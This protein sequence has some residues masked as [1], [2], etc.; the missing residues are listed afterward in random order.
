MSVA[1][2]TCDSSCHCRWQSCHRHNRLLQ[3]RAS[4][5]AIFAASSKGCASGDERMTCSAVDL[6]SSS[7][8][9]LAT[10]DKMRMDFPSRVCWE[11]VNQQGW[12]W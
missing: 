4:R 11:G 6:S 1:E 10:R 7:A 5:T 12:P 9:V 3:S 2:N 8:L